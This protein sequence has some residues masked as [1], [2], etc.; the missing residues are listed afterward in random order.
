MK[1]PVKP[2]ATRKVYAT[3]EFWDAGTVWISKGTVTDP[4]AHNFKAKLGDPEWQFS[5]GPSGSRSWSSDYV[6]IDKGLKDHRGSMF[7]YAEDPA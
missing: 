7:V 2:T 3:P 6:D 5:D 4:E 1:I